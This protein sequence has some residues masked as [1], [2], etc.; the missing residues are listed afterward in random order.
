MGFK[1]LHPDIADSILTVANVAALS[2]LQDPQEGDARY[3]ADVNSLYVFDGAAW[4]SATIGVTGPG[5]STDNAIARFDGAGGATIQNSTVTIDDL[6]NITTAGT[7]DGR[8]VSTDGAA[9]DA[10]VASTANPHSVTKAQVGLSNVDNTSDATKNAAI[11]T[12]TNKKLDDT[13]TGVVDTSDPTKILAFEVGGT[14]GTSTTLTTAQTAN[15]AVTLPDAT[16]TLVGTDTAQTLTNKT[17]TAPTITDATLS[18]NDSSSAF[19]LTVQS[20]SALTGDK[21]L[22]INTNDGHRTLRLEGNLLKNGADQLILATT[23]A[24]NVTLP[25]AGTLSTLAGI[26]TLTNKTLTS[27][28]ITTPTGIVKGDVGLGNV[29]NTSDATKNAAVATLTNKTLTSPVINSPTGIVKGDVGL[30]NVDNTSDAT[31]NAAVATLTNK[32]IDGDDNTLQDLPV[33][34]IKTVLGDANKVLVRDASGVPTSALLVNA[35][36]DAA[37]A[38]AGSKIVSASGAT[39]GVVT[40]AAQSFAGAKTFSDGVVFSGGGT[41]LNN[42]T[43]TTA[44]VVFNTGAF[45]GASARSVT[46]T[47][48]R[49]GRLVV[50][51]FLQEAGTTNATSATMSTSATPLSSFA[52]TDASGITAPINTLIASGVN[53]IG[54]ATISNTGAVTIYF[55]ANETTTVASGA[56]SVGF[57]SF[58]I[59]YY[60]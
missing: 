45:T 8:D 58:S 52:P 22:T 2:S 5:S 17:L 38:I 19:A 36:V 23:A 13:T 43:E 24:T 1:N 14:T 39:S 21:T 35:N 37:A 48:T 44:A 30:G 31:K 32:I 3:V 41:N 11:A 15:R 60:L 53:N 33:T 10:H 40:G 6:G 28:A 59:T 42:Y 26:E 18:L 4:A 55:H 7:V 29:D 47:I 34:A 12:L 50:V 16:T 20:T 54:Y 56:T 27:P 9:L 46:A 51:S 49:I 25:T 57:R